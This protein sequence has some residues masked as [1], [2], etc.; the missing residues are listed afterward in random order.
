MPAA[1]LQIMQDSESNEVNVRNVFA[2]SHRLIAM[3][4]ASRG[5]N[6]GL[7]PDHAYWLAAAPAFFSAFCRFC[8]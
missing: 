3:H 5:S 8:G 1:R 4:T 6:R 7:P 2:C